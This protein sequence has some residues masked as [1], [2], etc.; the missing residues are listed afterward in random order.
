MF[1]SEEV[2]TVYP[3]LCI[4]CT[5]RRKTQRLRA[6]G[7][8]RNIFSWIGAASV[9]LAELLQNR[10]TGEKQIFIRKGNTDGE[11]RRKENKQGRLHR[12]ALIGA[13]AL[14]FL[15]DIRLEAKNHETSIRYKTSHGGVPGDILALCLPAHLYVKASFWNAPTFFRQSTSR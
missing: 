11:G 9:Q 8:L 5:G 3:G 6:S 2:S 14:L 1:F 12:F 15:L 13:A 7:P 10:R 4:P